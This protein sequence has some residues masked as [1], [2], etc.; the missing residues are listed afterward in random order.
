M[1]A[2]S[3]TIPRSSH[4]AAPTR[5]KTSQTNK[6]LGYCQMAHY[7]MRALGRYC[8]YTE[9]VCVLLVIDRT[10]GCR[11]RPWADVSIDRFMDVTGV[12]RRMIEI[13]L[14][15]LTSP[16][17]G[18]L[19]WRKGKPLYERGKIVGYADEYRVAL[20]FN[21][22]AKQFKGDPL[23]ATCSACGLTG[24]TE[25]DRGHCPTP[26]DFV[27]KVARSI[28]HAA[29]LCLAALLDETAGWNQHK[30]QVRV[31]DLAR[32]TGQSRRGV[33]CAMVELLELG[34]IGE[35]EVSGDASWYWVN[36]GKFGKLPKLAPRTVTPKDPHAESTESE[37]G[38]G[39]E[40]PTTEAPKSADP[41][42]NPW[43]RC[44]G[45]FVNRDVCR[46]RGCGIIAPV[47]PANEVVGGAFA[48]SSPPPDDA[49]RSESRAGPSAAPKPA[50][51]QDIPAELRE[52]FDF[53]LT[54]PSNHLPSL[55]VTRE[56]ANGLHGATLETLKGECRPEA[57]QRSTHP[58]KYVAAIARSLGAKMRAVV[59]AR[60]SETA[61]QRRQDIAA[62]RDLSP[63]E[64]REWLER[65]EL[66]ERFRG[67]LLEVFPEL[68]K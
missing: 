50:E 51:N 25:P 29:Y 2:P 53:L 43:R 37:P 45:E 36:Q 63:E 59:D 55:A 67:L 8:N 48:G 42:E 14:E 35:E 4:G 26:H 62:I 61:R 9:Y 46:C 28:T 17:V 5:E 6:A 12:S 27:L 33:Q 30:A 22:N 19:E 68:A 7:V 16:N 24:T 66:L 39:E 44:A 3:A 23:Y 47:S 60:E 57:I 21:L 65:P 10:I 31:E 64:A 38:K 18:W 11:N 54:L 13:S 58:F 34:L 20:N 40:T 49:A 1:S 41:I 32:D 15:W 56:I 52:L